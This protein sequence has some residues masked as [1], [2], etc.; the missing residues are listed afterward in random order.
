MLRQPFSALRPTEIRVRGRRA[1]RAMSI[2][3]YGMA[4]LAIAAAIL[5]GSIR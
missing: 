3:Q 2:L 1:D 4:F 5:L